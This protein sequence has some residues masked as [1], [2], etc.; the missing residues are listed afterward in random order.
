MGAGAIY[1]AALEYSSQKIRVNAVGP[2]FINTPLVE[3]GM[4]QE[5]RD[6]LVA[7]HP[8]GR[9]GEASEVAELVL[10]LASDKASF[11]TGGYYPVDGGYL[12]PSQILNRQ[13]ERCEEFSVFID[14]SPRCDSRGDP[15]LG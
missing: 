7:L 1:A 2:G 4:S 6:G 10:W 9:L 3:K 14:P 11:E 8:I 15:D 12:A 5:A 13:S